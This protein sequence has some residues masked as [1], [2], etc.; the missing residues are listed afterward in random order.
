MARAAR[1]EVFS[2]DEIAIVH[3]MNRIVRRAF[4]MGT[5]PQTGKNYDY[6]RQWIEDLLQRFAASFG[7]DL[8]TFSILSNH[9]HLILRSRPDVVSTWSDPEVARRWLTICPVRKNKDGSPKEP[10]KSE[11]NWICSDRKKLAVIRRRLS[12]ISWWMRLLCQR[13][14]QRANLED[15]QEGTFWNRFKAVRILDEESLLACAAYVDLN[16]IRAAMARTLEDSKHTSV[17]RRIESIMGQFQ[18]D[19]SYRPDRFLAPIPVIESDDKLLVSQPGFRCSDKGF[20]QIREEAYIELLD[21]TARQVASGKPGRTDEG[22][23]PVLERLSIKPQAW[24]KLTTNFRKLFSLVA[25]HP[26]C[27]DA[28][29]NP[30]DN[31]PYYLARE[32]RQLLSA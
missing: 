25:G 27:V 18:D 14:A 32:T 17:Q 16:P 5:D 10:S 24:F 7:I 6:R 31:K 9:F 22:L 29:V 20:L 13:I 26:R 4:L 21:W 8:L 30:I 28:A 12:D 3:V 1:R 2:P 15:D 23:P 19:A 11:I